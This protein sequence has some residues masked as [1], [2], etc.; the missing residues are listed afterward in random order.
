MDAELV[1]VIDVGNTRMKLALFRAGRVIR[2][3]AS[4][5]GDMAGVTALLNGARPQAVVLGSVSHQ[6]TGFA[7][8]LA[9]IAP[10][11]IMRGDGPSP[12]P[13]KVQ[14]RAT[15]GVDRLANVVAA[16]WRF[17]GRAALVVDAGSCVTYDLVEPDGTHAGGIIA[18]GMAMRA[19]AMHAYSARLPEVEPGE[20][21]ARWGLRTDEALAAGIHHGMVGEIDGHFRSVRERYPQA[22]LLLSGGD[23]MR[24]AKAL[25]CGIFAVPLL[26]LE[27]LH[28]LY[29]HHR[30][31]AGDRYGALGGAGLGTGTAG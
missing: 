18:P 8:Q 24:F 16:A 12:F 28:A 26:T 22:V 5:H 11:T 1:L 27:G 21:P 4:A 10:L 30:A 15:L 13:S 14:E 29:L 31:L 3:R 20:A 9:R 19:R 2:H 7:D 25:K 17:P 23:A 6:D